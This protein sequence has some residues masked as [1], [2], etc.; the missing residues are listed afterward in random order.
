MNGLAPYSSLKRM[1]VAHGHCLHKWFTRY[2]QA[3][4]DKPTPTGISLIVNQN[5]FPSWYRFRLESNE[6][7]S[8]RPQYDVEDVCRVFVCIIWLD[9]GHLV[10]YALHYIQNG[11]KMHVVE[12]AVSQMSNIDSN[13]AN[14]YSAH[15]FNIKSR[16]LEPWLVADRW[17][18]IQFRTKFTTK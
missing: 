13:D 14:K 9:F 11:I 17:S 10:N 3:S 12:G 4:T 6:S 1:S 18:A 7:S 16:P 2:K 5:K 15:I 8:E